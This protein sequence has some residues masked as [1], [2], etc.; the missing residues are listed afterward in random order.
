MKTE[1]SKWQS[2]PSNQQQRSLVVMS[3]GGSPGAEV[4]TSFVSSFAG[5]YSLCNE[6]QKIPPLRFAPVGMTLF[7]AEYFVICAEC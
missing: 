5:E 1:D 6:K 7:C 3:S 4:E 2:A